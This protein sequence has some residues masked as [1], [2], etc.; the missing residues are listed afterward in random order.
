MAVRVGVARS[1]RDIPV[2]VPKFRAE[3]PPA[4]RR[5]G[6][7]GVRIRLALLAIVFA[8]GLTAWYAIGNG[9]AANQPLGQAQ[10]ESVSR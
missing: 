3:S 9:T 2:G 6:G 8:S 4:S 5:A 7:L 10:A 1:P